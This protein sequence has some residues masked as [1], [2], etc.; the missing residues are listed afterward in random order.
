MK[1]IFPWNLKTIALLSATYGVIVFPLSFLT[2]FYYAVLFCISNWIF[3]D[4]NFYFQGILAGG[5]GGVWGYF[6]SRG[7]EKHKDIVN[8]VSSYSDKEYLY[9]L[10]KR[11]KVWFSFLVLDI[12][13][14]I[15]I[16]ITH[17]Y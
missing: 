5:T 6:V 14:I 12:L 16:K 17:L 2:M 9:L 13:F 7:V 10:K 15:F 4:M 8:N 3:G 11:N 1:W